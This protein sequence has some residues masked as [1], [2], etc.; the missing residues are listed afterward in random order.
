[1]DH[2]TSMTSYRQFLSFG[3]LEAGTGSSERL[4]RHESMLTTLCVYSGSTTVHALGFGSVP[5]GAAGTVRKLPNLPSPRNSF[6]TEAA[7]PLRR[8]LF[9]SRLH[10]RAPR[11]AIAEKC[12]FRGNKSN[13]SSNTRYSYIRP[14]K[15]WSLFKMHPYRS[16][17]LQ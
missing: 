7:V 4:I 6:R 16:L 12:E 9:G 5:N 1:M 11:N 15:P 2:V 13:R 8:V 10:N 3:I 14:Q 17:H